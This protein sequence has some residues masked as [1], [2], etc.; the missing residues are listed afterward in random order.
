MKLYLG[1][2]I[3]HAGAC[4]PGVEPLVVRRVDPSMVTT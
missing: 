1:I 3:V 2:E 4:S